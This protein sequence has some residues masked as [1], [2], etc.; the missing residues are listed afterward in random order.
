VFLLSKSRTKEVYPSRQRLREIVDT[1]DI[2][3]PQDNKQETNLALRDNN[4]TIY[5][6]S[7]AEQAEEQLL[8]KAVRQQ[9]LDAENTAR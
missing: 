6:Q 9:Q 8:S 2:P 4:V 3:E 7:D 1:I 5:R